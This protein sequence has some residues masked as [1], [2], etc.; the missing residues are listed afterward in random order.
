MT[1]FLIW[2]I[3]CLK[4]V[5]FHEKD[6]QDMIITFAGHAHISINDRIKETVKEQI[7]A[8]IGRTEP[9]TCYLGGYGD[10]DDICARACRELKQEYSNIEVVYVTPYIS[11]SE[12]TKI[13]KMQ[14]RGLCDTSVYPPIEDTPPK[15]AISKR[16]EWM[17]TRADIIIAYVN[18]SYGGAYQSLRAAKRKKKKIIN[19]GE[20]L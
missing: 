3:I 18:R 14:S 20:L 16:N 15:F 1:S 8:L 12:Q 9:I 19:I 10:F 11:L 13:Q 4:I 7:R 6:G 2:C 17:M 5:E